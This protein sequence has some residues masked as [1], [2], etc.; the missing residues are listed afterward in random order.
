MRRRTM[1]SALL[2][3]SASALAGCISGG[4]ANGDGSDDESTNGDAGDEGDD[5]DGEESLDVEGSD[6]FRDF[7]E[8]V[9][10][11]FGV[12]HTSIV[13]ADEDGSEWILDYNRNTLGPGSDRVKTDAQSIGEIYAEHVPE[14][15]EHERLTGT[16]HDADL[17]DMP[18]ASYTIEREWAEAY[19]D[20]EIDEDEYERRIRNAVD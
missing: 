8:T 19:L 13:A 12:G 17:D 18:V 1:V 5:G 10:S 9:D 20:G 3:A 11:E 4:D 15:D 7:V 14:D 2:G 16:G 6:A